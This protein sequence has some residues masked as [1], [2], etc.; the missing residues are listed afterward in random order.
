MERARLLCVQY[1]LCDI[2]RIDKT[3]LFWKRTPNRILVSE[4]GSGDKKLKDRIT[5]VF[6]ANTDGSEKLDL[7]VIRRSKNPRYFKRINIHL[8]GVEYRFNKTK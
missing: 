4:S 7:S 2:F 1:I 3:G 5:L 8:L 6:I